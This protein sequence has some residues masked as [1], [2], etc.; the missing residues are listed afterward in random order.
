MV[1]AVDEDIDVTV[2]QGYSEISWY[3]EDKNVTLSTG[4]S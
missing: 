3:L 4:E 2:N 1:S